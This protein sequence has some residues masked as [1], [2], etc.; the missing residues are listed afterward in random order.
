MSPDCAPPTPPP[1]RQGYSNS[2]GFCQRSLWLTG[3]MSALI[4]WDTWFEPWTAHTA[5]FPVYVQLLSF[6]AHVCLGSNPWGLTKGPH[7]WLVDTNWMKKSSRNYHVEYAAVAPQDKDSLCR[8][9]T[10]FSSIVQKRKQKENVSFKGLDYRTIGSQPQTLIPFLT[11]LPWPSHSLTPTWVLPGGAPL[12]MLSV[13]LKET[14]LLTKSQSGPCPQSCLSPAVLDGLWAPPK[15]TLLCSQPRAT[16]LWPQAMGS[17]RNVCTWRAF[18]PPCPHLISAIILSLSML[19]R[20]RGF[21]FL[22]L[23]F[24]FVSF[25]SIRTTLF[26]AAQERRVYVWSGRKKV[27]NLMSLECWSIWS[28]PAPPAETPDV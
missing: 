19:T 12:P 26:I 28:V 25:S 8:T 23:F 10:K 18:C 24:V 15:R 9:E 13:A 3:L 27:L 14:W 11:C 22:V 1:P 2:P 21:C 4:L 16:Y 7:Y 6:L 20:G 17:R 5:N